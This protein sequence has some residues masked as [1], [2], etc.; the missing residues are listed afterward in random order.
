[1]SMR[2]AITSNFSHDFFSNGLAQNVVTL[3]EAI[4]K[5]GMDPFFIDFSELS[6]GGKLIPHKFINN[7]K[8]ISW[9]NYCREKTHTDVAIGASIYIDPPIDQEIKSK[10][11][12][13]KIASLHYG[14]NLL[15]ILCEWFSNGEY[16]ELR[17]PKRTSSE[18][19]P[20]EC[21]LSPHYSFAKDYFEFTERCD[22]KIMPYIWTPKFITDLSRE[23][24]LKLGYRPGKKTNIAV[25]EPNINVTKNFFIP[26]LAI[27]E[28]L[29]R[30]PNAFSEAFIYGASGIIEDP[31]KTGIK[32]YLLESTTCGTQLAAGKIK[33]RTREKTSGFLH[34]LNPLVLSHQHLNELNYTYL[35]A[36]NFGYPLVHNAKAIKEFGYYY[37]NFELKSAAD[38]IAAASKHHDDN[39]GEYISHGK[40]LVCRYSPNNP[41]NQ[42]NIEKLITDLHKK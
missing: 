21:W 23:L 6:K 1:M 42:A 41:V 39:L 2:I 13:A 25:L 15:S 20:D 24:G 36:I 7:K 27:C 19:K 12:K 17:Q 31:K 16:N 37:K 32:E 22:V 5:I 9:K 4:E 34:N 30:D 29:E 11:P 35:E 40:E 26:L 18:I 10:S 28:L 3:Y 33:F 38:M 8:L 14:N